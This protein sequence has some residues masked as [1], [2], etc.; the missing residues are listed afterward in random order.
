MAVDTVSLGCVG[1]RSNAVDMDHV[2]GV[3]G[4]NVAVC[5]WAHFAADGRGGG[6]GTSLDDSSNFFLAAYNL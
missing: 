2:V 3:S 6:L 4:E 1:T 5:V